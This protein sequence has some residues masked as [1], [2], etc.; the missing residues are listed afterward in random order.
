MALP[1]TAETVRESQSS[2]L[3]GI[4]T[5]KNKPVEGAHVSIYQVHDTAYRGMGFLTSTTDAG[6]RFRMR[7]EPGE[8]VVIARKRKDFSGI[9]PLKKGDLFCFFSG[10]PLSVSESRE[11]FVELPCYPKDSIETFVDEKVYPS[12]L[13]RKSGGES[14]RFREY[15]INGTANTY[16]I[17]G[18]VT[19]LM[20]SPMPGL[21]V[22]AY[23]GRPSRMFQMLYLRT[24]PEYMVKTDEKGYYVIDAAEKGPYFI[25]ARERV[26][27][28]PAKDEYYGLYEDNVNHAVELKKGSVRNINVSVSR[29][30]ADNDGVQRIAGQGTVVRD[31]A[32]PES[33]VIRSDTIWEGEIKISGTVYVARGVTL[34]INPGTKIRFR[35]ID[36]N[37]DGVGDGRLRIGGRL[38]AEG[39]RDDAIRFTS[40]EEEPDKMD[41]SYVVL[42]A[43]AGESKVRHCVFKHAFTGIQVHFSKAVITDSIFKDNHEGI[44]FGRAELK[45]EHNDILLNNYGIRYTRL[46]GPVEITFNNIRRNKIGIFHVPSGQ[47]VVDFNATFNREEV[48]HR[49]QPLVSQNNITYNE[50]YNFKLGERQGYNIILSDNW[51]GSR[52]QGDVGDSIYDAR[53]DGSLGK[54]EY[55]PILGSPVRGGGIRR[56]VAK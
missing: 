36:R 37:N 46:E 33:T 40:A 29:V 51:W 23:S 44:R 45:I 43:A 26:G 52:K 25:V 16:K 6:G 53:R 1:V 55:E 8:Y 28:A 20:G 39:T 35:K 7:P 4:V 5:F 24:M 48:Y 47:N 15:Q 9:R 50:E 42:F 41:W 2:G 27:E 22:K 30:M 34:T 13:I 10:N 21:Y 14:I 19:D 31:R 3:S 18:K 38:I 17:Q 11:T 12:L 32:Y 49:D 56:G 54:A